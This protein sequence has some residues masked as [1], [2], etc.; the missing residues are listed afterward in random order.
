MAE[1][2]LP[3]STLGILGGGQLGRMFCRAA[4]NMGYQLNVLDPDPDSP[5]GRIADDHIEAVYTDEQALDYLARTCDVITTEFENVPAESMRRLAASRPVFPSANVLEIAQNRNREKAFASQA[6][7]TPAPNHPVLNE[8]DLEAAIGITGLPA[9]LKTATL[10]YDGK[11]QY[12]VD[13]LEQAQRALRDSGG[14]ECVLEQRIDLKKEISVIVARNQQGDTAVYPVGEN[15]HRNG[16]LHITIVPARV[17]D[18]IRDKAMR[19]ALRLVEELDYVGVLAVEFFIDS[20]DQLLFNEMAPRPH[21]SGHY[22]KD[23]CVTS[24]FEQQVRVICGLPPGDVSLISPVVMVNLLGDLW[25]PDW[26]LLLNEPNVKL[27]LYGKKQA[28]PGR[29]MGHYNVLDDDLEAALATARK[30][31]SELSGN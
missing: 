29:K 18:Q 27:H 19:Q 24:Q 30:I 3:G 5:A 8:G 10:G 15:Q 1:P 21:N 6:G 13:S 28:R 12:V 16:I 14:V 7:L 20:N 17:G 31:F 23:G 22:T 26:R 9:V 11:G 2:I 4:R 25:Q